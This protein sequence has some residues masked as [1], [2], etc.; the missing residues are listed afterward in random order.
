MAAVNKATVFISG[1]LSWVKVLGDPV[2]NFNKDGREWTFELEPDEKG[3]QTLIKHGLTDR[4][5]GRGYNIG[6]KGQHKERNPFI[7]LKKT[8]FNR[9]GNPNT[10]IRVY[11]ALEAPGNPKQDTDWD[12]TVLIGNGSS[13]DVKL[14]IRD[15]GMGKKKGI[16][17]VAF[18]VT[19]HVQYEASEFGGM[20]TSDE[21]PVNK[22]APKKNTVVEDFGPDLDDEIPF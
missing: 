12:K 16:Y 18:R 2:L 6:T 7:Q 4:I 1:K 10:P 19:D 14:D 11:D 15:Y 20:D 17:P 9:D 22:K 5:K 21:F 13:A 3:L 8:E